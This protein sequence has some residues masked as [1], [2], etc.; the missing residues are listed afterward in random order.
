MKNIHIL[1][2]DKPSRLAC[3]FD[4]LILNSRLLS[5]ILYKTQNIYIASDEEIKKGDWFYN[6][7]SLKPEPFK[8]CENGDGYVN[9]SKYSHYRIDCKKIILTTDQDL[10]KDGVQAIDDEFLEWF[11]K[12]PSCEEVKTQLKL[13]WESSKDEYEIIIPK[14]EPKQETL[15][16]AAERLNPYVLNGRT[17]FK[18]GLYQGAKWQ[19]ERSYNEED[20]IEFAYNYMEERKNKG[21]RALMPELLIKQF[22]KK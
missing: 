20:M 2:T 8:A 16:E 12:N 4:K 15:E 14:E 18:E 3:D 10:I 5:P 7:I 21:V 22:K 1:P 9:C 6:T 11:V 17:P 19:Q 13:P